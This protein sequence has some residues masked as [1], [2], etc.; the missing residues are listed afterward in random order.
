MAELYFEQLNSLGLLAGLDDV[1]FAIQ[2]R[3]NGFTPKMRCMSVLASLAQQ[4]S[5]LTDWTM[6]HRQDTRLT[7]WMDDRI[8]PH[9]STLSRTL[10]AAGAGTIE[11][12]RKTLLGPLTDQVL[13]SGATEGQY[14][15]IDVDNKGLP[16]EGK[17]YQNTTTGRMADG[18]FASGYRLHLVSLSNSYPLEMELTGAGAHAVPSAVAMIKRLWPRIDEKLRPRVVFRGDSN[19]G[20]VRFVRVLHHYECGYLLK[21]YNAGT[22]RTLWRNHCDVP[23]VRI[24]RAGTADLLAKD[25][26]PTTLKGMSRK[27]RPGKDDYRRE[28][29]VTVPRVVVYQEDPAQVEEDKKPGCF[30]LLTTLSAEAYHYSAGLRPKTTVTASTRRA[31]RFD[32]R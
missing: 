18:G 9:P 25:L 30:A 5:R 13:L 3:K 15:F 12:L 4:C 10:A 23:T 6:A 21:S 1:P 26:G 7:Y 29:K 24:V 11:A 14:V 2:Q 32:G 17:T 19:H 20:S 27:K 8:A 16:A 31:C 22:A 28:C